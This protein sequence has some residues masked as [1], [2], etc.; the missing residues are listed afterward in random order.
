MT[1]KDY[2][3]RRSGQEDQ[4]LPEEQQRIEMRLK[5]QPVIREETEST[6]VVRCA[7]HGSTFKIFCFQL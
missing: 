6:L 7:F 3:N 1:V 5:V 4:D 2:L